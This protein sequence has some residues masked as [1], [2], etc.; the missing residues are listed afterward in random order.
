MSKP[1]VSIVVPVYNCEKYLQECLDSIVNQTFKDIEIICVNDSST[2][3]SLQILEEYAKKDDRIKIV[4]QPGS[5][6]GM[7]RNTGLE[8]ARGD[9][10]QFLDADDY[11]DLSMLSKLYDK[12]TSTDS[13]VAFCIYSK[14]DNATKK[15]IW[16]SNPKKSFKHYDT[17]FSIKDYPDNFFQIGS[18]PNIWTRL[19]KRSFIIENGIRFSSTSSTNDLFF[20]YTALALAKK[21]IFYNE[22][23]VYYRTNLADSITSKNS[24]DSFRDI[25]IVYDEL[26]HF[27]NERNIF[28]LLKKSFC[29][30]FEDSFR[31]RLK[32]LPR[33]KLKDALSFIEENKNLFSGEI[34]ENDVLP[35]VRLFVKSKTGKFRIFYQLKRIC[36]KL[37]RSSQKDLGKISVIIPA[38]NRAETIKKCLD[39]LTSQTYRNIEI[40]CINDGSTDNTLQVLKEYEEK[41]ARV[42]VFSHENSGAATSR[43]VGLENATGEYLM[44][45]DSDDWY[46]PDM[47]E[48]MILT[49]TK[50]NVDLVMCDTNIHVAQYHNRPQ[51][52]LDYKKLK[53]FKKH[54]I[55]DKLRKKINIL[56]W[57]KIFKKSLVD[58]F[59]IK[60]PE[61]S[62]HEDDA[63]TYAYMSVAKNIYGL[64]QK[65]YNFLAHDNSIMSELYKGEN[66]GKKLDRIHSMKHLFLFLKTNNLFKELENFYID[67]LFAG[68][69]ECNRYLPEEEKSMAREL[70][71]S[72]LDEINQISSKKYDY[73]K[74]WNPHKVIRLLGLKIKIR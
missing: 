4:T 22:I 38:Y 44:F 16:V 20:V 51:D 19:F 34:L 64:K 69:R 27:L 30:R 41:D 36:E 25:I 5:N 42:K 65:L 62:A 24:M 39:S 47:C 67:R 21:I 40:I 43:N 66:T 10:I 61:V 8:I 37:N 56:I 1:K 58:K 49:I 6:A 53:L 29:M 17:P 3:N 14:F 73:E 50:Q 26:Y 54:K 2:D 13:D 68:I 12:I 15:N 7:A 71:E 72:L 32:M 9:Y 45:C 60:F 31:Y 23:L 57:N 52:N 11:F 46:E 74:I 63:F 18:D 55:N 35:N 33:N 28:Q 48:Q 70:A 59:G